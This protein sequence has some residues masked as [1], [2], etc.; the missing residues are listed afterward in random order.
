[1]NKNAITPT[2]NENYPDWYQSVIK[3]ADLAENGTVRGCMIIKP[4][5]CALWKN[6][7]HELDIKIKSTNHQNFY[8]PM[9]MPVSSLE[10]EAQHV[11]GFVKECAVVTHYRLGIDENNKLVPQQKLN[12]P[13]IIRPTS[14]ALIGEAYSR[15]IK[16]YRDLPLLG[17]QWANVMR[18]EMRPRLFLRTSEF[19]WQEGH[20]AHATKEEAVAEAQ[21]MLNIYAEFMQ[22]FLAIPVIIGEKTVG[23]KFPGADITY[24]LEAMMQ[25]KKALQAGTSHFLGQNFAK[26]FNISFLDKDE[27]TKFAW[28]TSWGVT[29]RL[30]GGLIMVHSDDDGLVLPPKIAPIQVVIVPLVHTVANE[31]RQKLHNYCAQIQQE[32]TAIEY[33]DNV[34]IKVQIDE[35]DKRSTEKNWEWIKKGVPIK[36]EIGKKELAEQKI[37]FSRRDQKQKLSATKDDFLV[38]IVA[39]LQDIQNNLYTKAKEFMQHNTFHA[40]NEQDF[41]NLFKQDSGFVSAYWAEDNVIAKKI[42]QELQVTARCIP[43]EHERSLTGKCIFT[44]NLDG[45]LTVFAKAY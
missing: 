41:Y 32:L 18:W 25:D 33:F 24:C 11:E 10:K 35:R 29:T 2:R 43:L 19:L 39:I 44:G 30:I 9:L 37:Y 21:Q 22:N 45:K 31:D 15:W 20:T 40:E 6:I 16:S 23:E 4:W 27:S 38:N 34:K 5:G 7:Q 17:N 8:F 28:T 42:K 36:L 1:M 26:A 3:E 13:L 12:E 14:E